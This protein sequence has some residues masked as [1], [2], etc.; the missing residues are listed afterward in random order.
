MTSDRLFPKFHRILL[1]AIQIIS[2]AF[3][4]LGKSTNSDNFHLTLSNQCQF[5]GNELFTNVMKQLGDFIHNLFDHMC[6]L[7]NI[8]MLDMLYQYLCISEQSYA[9]H[10]R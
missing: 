3:H 9:C 5:N 1:L 6:F 10:H 7:D 4:T 8:P 2:K